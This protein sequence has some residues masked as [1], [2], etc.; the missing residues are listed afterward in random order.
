MTKKLTPS[1][2]KA[3]DKLKKDGFLS[4]DYD[5]RVLNGLYHKGLIDQKGEIGNW[6]KAE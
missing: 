4:V 6:Y 1:Q 5:Y 2:I 3:M